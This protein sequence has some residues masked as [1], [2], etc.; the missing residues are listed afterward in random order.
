MQ[1]FIAAHI[2]VKTFSE[3]YLYHSLLLI[4]EKNL[5]TIILL[6]VEEKFVCD[7]NNVIIINID[8]K[9]KIIFN[10][11]HRFTLPSILRKYKA[12]FFL[13]N[14]KLCSSQTSIP[15]YL[16]ID[17]D[18]STIKKN[19]LTNIQKSTAVFAAEEFIANQLEHKIES[20]K[21]K[22]VFHG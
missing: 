1:T 11:W 15:Q 13:T 7:I 12:N 10:Y 6:I 18:L 19:T 4:A 14:H 3:N 22:I 21:I 17:E 20:E 5:D 8:K 9:N 2:K 16:F